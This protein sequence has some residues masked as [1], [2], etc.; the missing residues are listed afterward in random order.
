MKH[1]DQISKTKGRIGQFTRERL[2]LPAEF[3]T[4]W[5]EDAQ[6]Q[7]RDRELSLRETTA[8]AAA[9]VVIAAAHRLALGAAYQAVH[10]LPGDGAIPAPAN[11]L[12]HAVN[13]TGVRADSR[14]GWKRGHPVLL[15]ADRVE[16]VLG[17][18]ATVPQASILLDASGTY[19][20][21][22]P[23]SFIE[24]CPIAEPA[25]TAGDV[26][27]AALGAYGLPSYPMSECGITYRVI[28]LD[29]TAR[30][31][32]VHAGPRLFVMSDEHATRSIEDH[33]KPWTITLHDAVGDEISTLY[34]GPHSPGGIA[35]E[36]ADCGKFAASWI[37]DNAHAFLSR[38]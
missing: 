17:T 20:V 18:W 4:K 38:N 35:E 15:S 11:P 31:E 13:Y 8:V 7:Q 12:A 28:P 25:P 26:L 16:F 10:P 19:T 34:I 23:D 37:R 22:M 5:A 3:S 27:H 33:D 30:G 21:A 36:S 2:L 14:D 6:E 1:H 9:Y 29:I 24:L 32:A